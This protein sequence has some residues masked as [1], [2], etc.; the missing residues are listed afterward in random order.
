MDQKHFSVVLCPQEGRRRTF[1]LSERKIR[2]LICAATA[3]FFIGAGALIDYFQIRFSSRNYDALVV[4]TA[5]Q[6]DQLRD[7]ETAVGFLEKKINAF[8]HYATKLN[9][10]AGIKP[11]DMLKPGFP[12]LS[13][14]K[15]PEMEENMGVGGS[16]I[17]QAPRATASEVDN[18]VGNARTI[19]DAQT[20]VKEA[21]EIDK[22]LGAMLTKF[23][24]IQAVFAVRPSISPT[25]GYR[26][27]SFG[28]RNDPFSGERSFHSG[29]DVATS[30]GNPV[31]ATAD[32]SVLRVGYDGNFGNCVVLNHGN[33]LTTLYGH[34]SKAT[35]R[36]GQ[37]VKRGDQI[38]LVGHTGRARGDHVH[39]EVRINGRTVN[40]NSYILTEY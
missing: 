3:A 19:S 5:S 10:F 13:D 27:S 1:N 15:P 30:R 24:E 22:D 23:E 35:V 17:S 18:S 14:I 20:L 29:V 8:R 32:G 36:V 40:P 37:Q 26:S 25:D 28:W 12:R 6:K 31:V 33:G 7:Y 39:Y 11:S 16:A 38:G 2:F 9:I 4:E 34:L 21:E